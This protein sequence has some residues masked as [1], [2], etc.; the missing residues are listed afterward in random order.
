M[1]TTAT[2]AG[3]PAGLGLTAPF[4]AMTNA[5]GRPTPIGQ[6]SSTYGQGRGDFD[7]SIEVFR[8]VMNITRTTNLN[9]M[10]PTLNTATVT[11]YTV[12]NFPG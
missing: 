2:G 1:I 10:M 3:N 5:F 7:T 9:F 6:T 12:P 4:W 11:V 8:Q